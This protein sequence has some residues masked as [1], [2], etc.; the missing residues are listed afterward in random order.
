[1]EGSSDPAV[2]AGMV[3]HAARAKE[4]EE[5]A[6]DVGRTHT[7][8]P[9][10]RGAEEAEEAEGAEEGGPGT[11][12]PARKRARGAAAAAADADEE[13]SGPT[14]LEEGQVQF[15]YRHA[16]GTASCFWAGL[17]PCG[18]VGSSLLPA[19]QRGTPRR[20]PKVEQDEVDSL[21]DVQRFFMLL[22]PSKPAG[23]CRLCV[24][25]K[26]LLPSYRKH[27]RCPAAQRGRAGGGRPA[28]AGASG[29]GG[30]ASQSPAASPCSCL[31]QLLCR[32]FGFV[33]AS[34]EG[35]EELLEGLGAKQYET[36][37]RGA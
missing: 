4:H 20:R 28:G 7:S 23:R 37:T 12:E 30:A 36:K 5:A 17:V 33:E 10:K 35:A 34:A 22:R 13:A 32:F 6:G 2:A 9:A 24:M 1:M 15:F 27:E 11:V 21:R 26:K 18:A 31:S 3:R 25:G 14:V 29:A 19:E 16:P 8:T